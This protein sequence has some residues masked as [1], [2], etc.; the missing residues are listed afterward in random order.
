MKLKK[1]F[2]FI[3]YPNKINSNK[4]NRGQ[5]QRNNKLKGCFEILKG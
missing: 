4:N 3:N 1:K 5:I 2:N